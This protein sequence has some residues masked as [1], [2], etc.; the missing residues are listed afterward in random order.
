MCYY[1][2]R[3][4]KAH[5]KVINAISMLPAGSQNAAIKAAAQAAPKVSAWNTISAPSVDVSQAPV[6]FAPYQAATTTPTQTSTART[7]GPM[8]AFA[9]KN[10]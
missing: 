7:M 2:M 1:L 5:S 9:V 8:V 4:G 6:H 3:Y 10:K